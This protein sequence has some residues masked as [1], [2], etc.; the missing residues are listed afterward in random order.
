[1]AATAS[2]QLTKLNTTNYVEW[3]QRIQ[4][5]AKSYRIWELVDPQ[6]TAELVEPRNPQPGDY[7]PGATSLA[8]LE[9]QLMEILKED[10]REYRSEYAQFDKQ[11]LAI[12]S[13]QRKIGETLSEAHQVMIY[14]E[15][16]VRQIL[17][18]LQ[19]RLKPT[20]DDQKLLLKS[21]YVQLNQGCQ[22][23][24][25]V[26]EWL[27]QW[28]RTYAEMRRLGMKDYDNQMVTKD[29]MEAAEPLM[30]EFISSWE[31]GLETQGKQPQFWET[32][33][34]FRRKW[35]RKETRIQLGV[36]AK[37][38][39]FPVQFQGR[40]EDNKP[41]QSVK[42]EAWT[43][44]CVC[45]QIHRFAH[46][47]Y[48]VTKVQKEDWKEDP[49]VIKKIKTALDDPENKWMQYFIL[50]NASNQWVIDYIKQE[51]AMFTMDAVSMKSSTNHPL[52]KAVILDSGATGHVCNDTN[53][54][55][56]K[57]TPTQT[58]EYIQ[59]GADRL[60]I[61]GYG[62]MKIQAW[63][64]PGKTSA[65][66]LTNVAFVP[67]LF[68]SA[69]SWKILK[70]KGAK[71]DTEQDT[72]KFNDVLLCNL[73]D[74]HNQFIMEYH[75]S[76]PIEHVFMAATKQVEATAETWHKRMGHCG[77][78]PL[79]HL[80]TEAI[81][82]VD[83][84]GPKTIDCE[85]C[86]VSKGQRIVSRQ[87]AQ[88]ATECF[89]RIHFDLIQYPL[90]FDGSRYVLHMLDDCTRKHFVYLLVNKDSKTLLL[91]LR[92]FAS[93]ILR[94][95][96][97]KIK[98]FH[99]DQD[100]G[101]GTEYDNWIQD[102]GIL[103]EWSAVYTPA[104]NGS[105]ERS[106][107]VIEI[108]A[109]CI[110]NEA[111]LPWDLWPECVMTAG[112]LLNR[113]PTKQLN[114]KTP[115]E[116]VRSLL[117]KPWKDELSH[118]RVF[119]C[120][121]YPWIP[122]VAKG[123]K[124][125]PRAQIGYLVGYE[126]RN[127]FRVWIPDKWEVIATRDVTFNENVFFDPN[128]IEAIQGQRVPE[129]PKFSSLIIDPFQLE[130][131]EPEEQEESEPQS[132][133]VNTDIPSRNLHAET[134]ESAGKQL[135]T[136]NNE[137][138]HTPRRTEERDLSPPA[139]IEAENRTQEP[140]LPSSQNTNPPP[141]RRGIDAHL[142]DANIMSGSRTRRAKQHFQF[143][144]IVDPNCG[145]LTHMFAIGHQMRNP[146]IH[147]SDLPPEPKSWKAMKTHPNQAQFRE[148]ARTEYEALVSKDTFETVPLSEKI[149]PIPLKWVFTY[150]FDTDGFLLK[151]K[152]R[153][154]V[155]GDLQPLTDEDNYA[156]T[157]AHKTFRTL[158]AIAAAFDLETKQL[159]AVN[160]FLN[161][162]LD[163]LVYCYFPHG[164]EQPNQCL[165]LK[166]ALYGLRKS[167]RLWLKHFGA[168]LSKL[169]LWSLPGQPCVYTNYDGIVIFFYVDDICCLYRADQASNMD[170]ILTDLMKL[171]EFHMLGEI[172]WFLGIRIIRDRQAKKIWLCQD[173]YIEKIAKEY[174]CD[175][176]RRVD[177]P[178]ST[179][180]LKE[181]EQI[182]SEE[183]KHEYAR[184]VGSILFPATVTRP[185]IARATSNL[186]EFMKNPSDLHSAAVDRVIAYLYSTRYLALEYS[187]TQQNHDQLIHVKT[188]ECAADAA[189]GNTPDRR[190][191]QGFVFKLFGGP[192]HWQS[193][194]QATVTTSS[195]EAELLG[196][197][198][199]AKELVWTR[200]LFEKLQFNPDCLPELQNDNLQTI[201]LLTKSDPLISTKLRH[202]DIHQ[203]W[204]RELVQR[205]EIHIS[206][207]PTAQMMADGMTK[208]LPR[209]KHA[210]FINM[211]NLVN[212]KSRIQDATS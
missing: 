169:T 142:S 150:K 167:P 66:T 7:K 67:G 88:R 6:G 206:W 123:D 122:T 76:D 96:K 107:G 129:F 65:I 119:G 48:L 157:L 52:R 141:Q 179:T 70:R 148:A 127:I 203:H 137:Q 165:R 181:N 168:S 13:L 172:T 184:R 153:I 124:M 105:A 207:I 20:D 31:V 108:K 19:E 189:F 183:A 4:T 1:M 121:A 182:S 5:Y 128:Q 84:P 116:T 97:K 196:V 143:T 69:V 186:A 102:E 211:L 139:P 131:T 178:L 50:K 162:E 202:V 39:A 37:H 210:E 160:A 111:N 38:T 198:F 36:G 149:H 29:F 146:R 126:S 47:P 63:I 113:T 9:P 54:V 86:S 78:E 152:A 17:Q 55:I 103:I 16:N 59:T 71:W 21:T 30:P 90:G 73:R 208:T 3:S 60:Q 24:K 22:G 204:L 177:S 83:G 205:K 115:I 100:T 42:P 51:K 145:S 79:K 161:A 94:I 195:T 164:F 75:H 34:A 156:A 28:E 40:T 199:A 138:L 98:I 99:S 191:I 14:G 92:R 158:I 134:T 12:A 185:D 180:E 45:S 32:V 174:E 18:L 77:P 144:D 188:M 15:D 192:I 110:C 11:S 132:T 147:R 133:A 117:G 104:Q 212:C 175:Q 130:Q 10:R 26:E 74:E 106:G 44:A 201:R 176:S 135:E 200:N 125:H 64:N 170:K 120:R 33:S 171:Y 154:C 155:R 101:L 136:Q 82:V 58:P 93:M 72:I 56:G 85:T 25:K 197:S 89:E 91:Q 43:K 49:E 61:A 151:H 114:W 57:L 68:T 193:S 81:K 8:Q 118:L 35:Q 87:P 163:E 80:D 27:T 62:S 23:H 173:A 46:C 140:V 194:K 209:Q 166:R 159:D 109:R 41:A 53:R 112:Y 95:Y 187:A 190:S 2:E